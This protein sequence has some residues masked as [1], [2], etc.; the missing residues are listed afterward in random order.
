MNEDLYSKIDADDELSDAEKREA[1]E[2]ELENEKFDEDD[3][4]N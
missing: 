4:S 2:A 1:Y 3:Y